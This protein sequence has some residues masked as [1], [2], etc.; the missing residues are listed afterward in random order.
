VRG[1]DRETGADV[2]DLRPYEAAAIL[3]GVDYRDVVTFD[4]SG[5]AHADL[6]KLSDVEDAPG[7]PA[8]L[9]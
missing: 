2:Y 9:P 7:A 6:R 4:G 8:A 3:F 1:R 5:R